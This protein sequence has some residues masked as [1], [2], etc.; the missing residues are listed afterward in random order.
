MAAAIALAASLKPLDTPRAM[1]KIITRVIPALM[2]RVNQASP[3]G[4]NRHIPAL[5]PAKT[6]LLIQKNIILMI[7]RIAELN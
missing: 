3:K 7:A 2:V 4:I 5:F 1:A 6:R